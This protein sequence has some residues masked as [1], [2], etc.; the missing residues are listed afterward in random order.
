MI[1]TKSKWTL[2]ELERKTVEFRIRREAGT[3]SGLGEF[4][5]NQNPD[6]LLAIDIATDEPGRNFGERIQTR[7]P[8][9]Q[10]DVDR[11]R[12]HPTPTVAEFQLL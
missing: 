3:A 6:G 1:W 5:V 10:S 11:I 12:R 7:F 2:A 4:L 9:P 8:L